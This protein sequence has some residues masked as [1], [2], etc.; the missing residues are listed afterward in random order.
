MIASQIQ[1]NQGEENLIRCHPL[2]RLG[3]PEEIANA[4]VFLASYY[5]KGMTGVNLSVDGGLHAQLRL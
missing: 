5:S 3:E 1:D 2:Q 4:A